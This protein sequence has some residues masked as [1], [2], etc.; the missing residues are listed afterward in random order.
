MIAIAS[1]V[2][3]TASQSGAQNRPRIEVRVRN[4][5]DFGGLA[6]ENLLG[7]EISDEP[8]VTGELLDEVPGRGMTAKRHRR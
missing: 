5:A 7:E 3:A 6:A 4:C 1:P 8:V 2:A